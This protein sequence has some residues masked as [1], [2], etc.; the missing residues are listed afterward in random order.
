MS[1]DYR[2]VISLIK[3]GDWDAAHQ[4]VQQHADP[5]SCL[6][7]AYLH[8]LEGDIDNARYWYL[9]ANSTLPTDD[10]A[11]ELD[12]LCELVEK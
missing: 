6:F 3:N 4:I 7:H 2:S 8:R 10:L 12:R 1:P 9:R 11:K 5:L